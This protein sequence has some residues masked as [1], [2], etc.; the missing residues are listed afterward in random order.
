[1]RATGMEGAMEIERWVVDE[2]DGAAARVLRSRLRA[3]QRAIGDAAVWP[4]LDRSAEAAADA[5]TAR[6]AAITVESL[7][8]AAWTRETDHVVDLDALATVLLD[9]ARATAPAGLPR[10]AELREGDVYWIVRMDETVGVDA[11]DEERLQEPAD[12]RV[13]LEA[14]LGAGGQVWDV[15]AAARQ[16]TKFL[17]AQ[18]LVARP[19]ER[20][21]PQQ[22]PPAAT[23]G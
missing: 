11:L 9:G 14:L 17:H 13:A 2:I 12:G 21:N 22:Q 16:R 3:D 20:P 19:S 15:T 6:D 23:D 5:G 1:M 4:V 7:P 8:A 10:R 18:V